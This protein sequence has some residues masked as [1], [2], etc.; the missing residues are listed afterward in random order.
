[1]DKLSLSS[2]V[3][4]QPVSAVIVNE[5]TERGTSQSVQGNDRHHGFL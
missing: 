4:D 1:M 2:S 5:T 3:H